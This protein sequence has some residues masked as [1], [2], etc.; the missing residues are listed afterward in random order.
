MAFPDSVA[1]LLWDVDPEGIDLALPGH[2]DLVLERV[3][4]RGTLDAMVWL[5]ATF[6]REVLAEFLASPRAT[7]LSP[8]DV[9]YWS[10]VAGVEPTLSA[11]SASPPGGGRP[12]W[13]GP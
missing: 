13:A 5:R 7:A 10:L 12:P 11:P 6:P 3:M 4:S 9:A 1:R 8:R 2:R